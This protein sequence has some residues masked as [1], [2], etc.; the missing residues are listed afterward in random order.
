MMKYVE[1]QM[2]ELKEIINADFKKEIIAFANADGG[3]IYVG[4]AKDGSV[5]GTAF[6]KMRS[7]NQELTFNYAGKYFDD[8]NILFADNNK[9][10]LK[11][12]DEDGYYTNAALLFSDQCAHIIRSAVYEGTGKT[13]FKTRKEFGGS[14]LK[15]MDDAY[16]FIAL[17]NNNRST[18]EGLKRIDYFDY[19]E[20][21]L[22]E[23]LINAV[24]HRDYGYS[25]SII[26]NI[27]DDRMEFVSLGGLVKG[28]T[29]VDIMGGVS[30][31]RNPIIANIFY[32]LELIESYG[33]GI[34][35]I[36]ESYFDCEQKPNFAPAPASFVVTLP[37]RNSASIFS[38]DKELSSEENILRLLSEKGQITRKDV[39]GFLG[40]SSFPAI[41]L[42]N[43][44]LRGGKIEKIGAARGTKYI[45]KN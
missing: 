20:Y 35:R 33:T 6:D 43:E 28:I 8:S 34:Q 26:I 21:A 17:N 25:G 39:E 19:P 40:S 16:E 15:Q 1:S 11:L 32:R 30:Q 2:V 5:R 45:T 12:I 42:L 29:L 4:V 37:N 44:L 36:I 41:N 22:R 38:Y 13:K 27:Y 31:T 14:I 3:D 18:F 10:T 9:R 23:A 24:V 7:V